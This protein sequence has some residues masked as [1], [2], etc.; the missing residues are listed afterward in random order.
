MNWQK[1]LELL[2]IPKVSGNGKIHN[3]LS[4]E[5]TGVHKYDKNLPNELRS[6]YFKKGLDT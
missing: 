1:R 5:T 2:H 3:I 4:N 6:V